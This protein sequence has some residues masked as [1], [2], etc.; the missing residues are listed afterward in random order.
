MQDGIAEMTNSP[1]GP[2]REYGNK[3]IHTWFFDLW[4]RWHCNAMENLLNFLPNHLP[5]PKSIPD[6]L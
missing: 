4:Q 2:N 6:E 5:C 3:P 1:L